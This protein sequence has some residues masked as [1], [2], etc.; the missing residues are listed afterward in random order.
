MKQIA[1]LFLTIEDPHFTKIWD[2]YFRG[3]S[4][5]YNL[6]LHPKNPKKITWKKSH[7]CTV[8][9]ASDGYPLKYKK[10]IQSFSAPF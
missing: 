6:Y 8:V 1:F 3:N 9:L 4:S 2:S 10:H 7:A 5:K